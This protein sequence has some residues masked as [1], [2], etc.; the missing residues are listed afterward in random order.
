MAKV[1]L[2]S[3]TSGTFSFGGFAPILQGVKSIGMLSHMPTLKTKAELPSRPWLPNLYQLL[4]QQQQKAIV[5]KRFCHLL[6]KSVP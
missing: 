4:F 5:A 6:D 1:N 2:S 3:P